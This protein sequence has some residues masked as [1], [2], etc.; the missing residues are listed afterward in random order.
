MNDEHFRLADQGRF[1]CDECKELHH[2]LQEVDP[3]KPNYEQA[4]QQR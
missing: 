3:D 1:D 2:E 4:R